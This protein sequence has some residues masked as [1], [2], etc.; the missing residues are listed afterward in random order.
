ML[1]LY[2]VNPKPAPYVHS[3]IL[4]FENDTWQLQVFRF[5]QRSGMFCLRFG[6]EGEKNEMCMYVL[7]VCFRALRVPGF[8]CAN[9]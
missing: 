4:A 8:H 7:Y 2:L 5:K 6:L 1:L 3:H 9:L